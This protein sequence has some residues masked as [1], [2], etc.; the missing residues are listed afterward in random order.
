MEASSLDEISLCQFVKVSLENLE[1]PPDK[2]Y[3]DEESDN[4]NV[5]VIRVWL[6]WDGGGA[7]AALKVALP[8][9]EVLYASAVMWGIMPGILSK[10]LC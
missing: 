4:W 10:C 9:P 7:W 1:V 2:C 8:I 6:A 5:C 3:A